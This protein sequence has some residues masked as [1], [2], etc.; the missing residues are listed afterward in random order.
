M[1]N[2]IFSRILPLAIALG[3]GITF[4]LHAQESQF[5]IAPRIGYGVQ[6]LDWSIAGNLDGTGPNIYSE[7]IWDQI[8]GLNYGLQ[9]TIRVSPRWHIILEG[10]YQQTLK[11]SAR[12]TDYGSD[13]RVAPFY[14]ERFNSDEGY[15][16]NFRVSAQYVLPNLGPISPR[17]LLGYEQ[18]G[19]RLF[20]LPL[21][22]ATDN[23]DLRTIYQTDWYG[24]QAALALA[25]QYH[26][27]YA[28]GSYGF[29]LYDYKAKANWNL[30]ESFEQP[31]SFRHTAL[32]LKHNGII[33]V[34]YQIHPLFAVELTGNYTKAYTNTGLDELYTTTS[35]GTMRTQFNGANLSQYSGS[36][37]IRFGF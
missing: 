8:Q 14:D 32:G 7:L 16:Y 13:N 31:V 4:N 34:G 23:L 27:F 6:N 11:G 3:M 20:L 18:L 35:I 15:F 26:G 24:G 1:I 9:G 21:P 22:G 37:G 29:G 5:T 30:I 2:S 33:R 25:Y 36:L 28:S 10:D 17:L 19:N 12:D